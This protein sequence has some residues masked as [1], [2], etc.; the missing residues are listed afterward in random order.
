MTVKRRARN[1]TAVNSRAAPCVV[2]VYEALKNGQW[3]TIRE[4]SLRC[5]APPGTVGSR[6]RDLRS[7]PFGRLSIEK[8]RVGPKEYAFRL[9]PARVTREAE[10]LVY[11]RC[12]KPQGLPRL[13]IRN[14]LSLIAEDVRKGQPAFQ[15][16]LG[17]IDLLVRHQYLDAE[18]LMAWLRER[19]LLDNGGTK[20]RL[21]GW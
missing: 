11:R 21:P 20:D 6:L 5:N 9:D 7:A 13:S 4:L 12:R 2:R 16:R 19:G 15:R 10:A 18:S 3:W 8:R 17:L 1:Q 14:F